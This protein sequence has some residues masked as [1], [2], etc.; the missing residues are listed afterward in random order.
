MASKQASSS[1]MCQG[2]GALLIDGKRLRDVMFRVPRPAKRGL[3]LRILSYAGK[4]IVG[5]RADAAVTKDARRRVDLFEEGA[6]RR[7]GAA[8]G[9]C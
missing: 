1:P 5:L 4:V 6:S 8:T 3:G 2:P 9:S 7:F